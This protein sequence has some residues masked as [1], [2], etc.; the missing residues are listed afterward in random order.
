MRS[1]F[2][3]SHRDVSFKTSL[4]FEFVQHMHAMHFANV[5]VLHLLAI[6]KRLQFQPFHI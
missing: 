6:S 2:E 4:L 3:M 5:F 1:A